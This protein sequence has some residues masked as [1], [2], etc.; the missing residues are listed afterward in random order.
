MV[1]CAICEKE[2][3]TWQRSRKDG[4]GESHNRCI[5]RRAAIDNIGYVDR[6]PVR[7]IK[8]SVCDA[9]IVLKEEKMRDWLRETLEAQ[10]IRFLCG[11]SHGCKRAGG[12]IDLNEDS[13][14][15][16]GGQC[17]VAQVEDIPQK[18]EKT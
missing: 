5:I 10:G 1:N 13:D 14:I 17:L 2:I 8:Y 7:P 6:R 15:L 18:K 9:L 4:E 12:V 3:E 11:H 16:V